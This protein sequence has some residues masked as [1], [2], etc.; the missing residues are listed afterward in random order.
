[1]EAGVKIQMK[2][3]TERIVIVGDGETA[4]LAYEYFTYDSPYEV[5]A[6]SVEREYARKTELFGLP[7]VHF[8]ELQERY[9][10]AEYRAFVAIS[11]TQ[12][13]RVRARL[14]REA[15]SKGYSLVSYV[16]SKAFVWRNAEIGENCFILEH[17]VIQYAVKI[18]NNVTLWSGNHIGHQSVIRDNAFISSHVVVSG[19]CE[20][21]ENCFLG[22][23]SAIA[24][25][26]RIAPD[27][28]IAMGAVINRNTEERKVYKGNPGRPSEVDSFTVFK[29]KGE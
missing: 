8:E 16:S 13:N 7:V 24:N 26:V 1:V 17:N 23:N 14:C 18:G 22:V 5:A 12:L 4:E 29:V 21:G 6:F 3:K 19:Y 11:Y 15:R 9:P 27:C 2:D 28:I 25:N 20:V 10:P